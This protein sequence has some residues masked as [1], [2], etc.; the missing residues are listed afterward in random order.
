L[1]V[2]RVTINHGNISAHFAASPLGGSGVG[3]TRGFARGRAEA[4][5]ARM[6]VVARIN[7]AGMFQQR[8]GSLVS[9]V[10]PI[11]HQLGRGGGTEIGIGTTVEHGKWLEIGAD[12]HI[13]EP[14]GRGYLLRSDGP[15]S[16][17]GNPT[18]LERP[19]RLVQHPGNAAR[20]WM[21]DAVRAVLP[22]AI[23]RVLVLK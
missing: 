22:G 1:T 16:K 23:V 10:V 17:G 5:A 20:H 6:A 12:P 15:N 4:I 13:I 19:Q 21:S 11:V 14:Q 18:P 9:S 7:A 3:A 8:T 2:S